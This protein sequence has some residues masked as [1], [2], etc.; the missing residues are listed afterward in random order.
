M[1]FEDLALVLTLEFFV[2][3]FMLF[4]DLALVLTLEFFYAFRF[5]FFSFLSLC[6]STVSDICILH[7][8]INKGLDNPK[9]D[10]VALF[11]GFSK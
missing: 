6:C 1:L 9:K 3:S 11:S 5:S 8:S 2:H 4:E 7:P 10:S